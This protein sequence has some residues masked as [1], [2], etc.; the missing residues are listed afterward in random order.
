MERH[1]LSDGERI[2]VTPEGKKIIWRNMFQLPQ[3]KPIDF[4]MALNY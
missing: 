4:F 3:D 2:E 1:S